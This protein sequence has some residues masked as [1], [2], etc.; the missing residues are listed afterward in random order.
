MRDYGKVNSTVWSSSTFG[1]LSDDGRLLSLYLMTC[2]HGTIAG[3][4]RLPDGYIVEDLGDRWP[5]ARVAA[6]FD[7]LAAHGF[8]RRCPVSKWVWIVKHLEQNKPENPNQRKAAAKVALAVP[9]DCDWRVEFLRSCG[10]G[11]GLDLANLVPPKE[12]VQEPLRNGSETLP[13]AFANQK[14]EQ[15]QEQE[16]EQ[17]QEQKQEKPTASS[18]AS[19]STHPDE[20]RLTGDAPPTPG[21]PPCPSKAVIDLYHQVLPELPRAV[22]VTDKRKK[23]IGGLWRFVL[24]SSRADGTRRAQTADQAL[25]WIRDYFERARA[26]DFLMGRTPRSGEHANWRCDLDFLLTEKGMKHVIEKTEVP[27]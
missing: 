9:D 12:R 19:L 24:T 1:K 14:Q 8:A 15:K 10:E 13:E 3:V 2:A 4:F 18:P 6:A 11:L 22:L 21:L 25:T 20:L 23:A 5:A 7:E 27:A 16:Q 26:N 17:E